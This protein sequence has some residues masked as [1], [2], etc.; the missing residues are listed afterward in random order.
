M[1]K[2]NITLVPI[3]KIDVNLLEYI[4][5]CITAAFKISTN[6]ISYR[7]LTNQN[8]KPLYGGKYCSTEILKQLDKC[9]PHSIQKILAVTDRDLYSPIF[10]SL[11]GEAQLG[12]GCALISLFRLYQEFYGLPPDKD[13]FLMRCRKEVI[14]EISH[15]FGLVHCEDINC[16]M[17]PSNNIIDTDVKSDSFC[18]NC[19]R[20][21]QQVLG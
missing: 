6:I 13:L 3:G 4:R 14:H 15:L 10:S 18:H 5:E 9:R 2:K 7:E 11:F 17:F 1:A 16:I 8:I 20:F 19:H 21:I 12:G